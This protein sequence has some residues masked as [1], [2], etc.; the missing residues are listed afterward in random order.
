MN[1][2]AERLVDEIM[3]LGIPSF[4]SKAVDKVGEAGRSVAGGARK[5][6]GAGA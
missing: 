5:A 6:V 4:V 2:K 1:S 3:G